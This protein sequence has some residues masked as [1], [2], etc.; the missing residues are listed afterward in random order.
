M[1]YNA[2]YIYIY[3]YIHMYVCKDDWTHVSCIY[4]HIVYIYISMYTHIWGR[5]QRRQVSLRACRSCQEVPVLQSI[6]DEHGM[7]ALGALGALGVLWC[8]A[9][10]MALRP[11]LTGP[12]GLCPHLVFAPSLGESEAGFAA[13]SL[14]PG[15]WNTCITIWLPPRNITI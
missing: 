3:V 7:G 12:G 2:M 8:T 9:F 5:C 11:F 14:F 13:S 1:Q 6:G 4:A 10:H 15:M